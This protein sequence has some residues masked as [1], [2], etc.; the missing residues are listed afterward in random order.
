MTRARILSVNAS[1]YDQTGAELTAGVIPINSAYM[2]GDVRRYGAVG[3][4]TADD[5]VALQSAFNSVGNGDSV[6]IP[7]THK[8]TGAGCNLTNKNN[9]KIFGPGTIS[10]ASANVDAVAIL[11]VGTCDNV[12]IEGIT[13]KGAG[14]AGATYFQYG[15]YSVSGQTLSNITVNTCKFIDLN[16]GASFNA[17]SAGTYKKV[18]ISNCSFLRMTGSIGGQGYGTHVAGVF[19]ALIH[20][21]QYDDCGRHDIYIALGGSLTA[22][23]DSGIIISNNVSRNHRLTS[24]DATYRP[25]IYVARTWGV[26][27]IGNRV[28]DYWDGAVGVS[29]D[30]AYPASTG[31]VEIIGNTF[32]GRKNVLASVLLGEQ[33]NPTSYRIFRVDFKS[34]RFYVDEAVGAVQSEILINNGTNI[35]VTGNT[36]FLANTPDGVIRLI[37]LGAFAVSTTDF[38]NIFV[39]DNAVS[40]SASGTPA[41][42]LLRFTRIATAVCSLASK[43]WVKNNDIDTQFTVTNVEYSAARTGKKII[44]QLPNQ[45]V[46]GVYTAADT[47]PSVYGGVGFLEVTNAGATNINGLT[48]GVDGQIVQLVFT[49]ANTTLKHNV[50]GGGSAAI[51]LIGAADIVSVGRKTVGLIYDSVTYGQ[52]L[53]LAVAANT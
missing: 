49:D 44:D 14:N 43:I 3:D 9:V 46:K 10:I 23:V 27:I 40:G 21:N 16:A 39:R 37:E 19:D 38:D 18:K 48:D 7:F 8:V 47:T 2:P 28:I 42:I 20:G 50:G 22:G 13:F 4:G 1:G 30:T 52:W 24:H 15:I 32:S 17:A 25:A 12:T 45:P 29:Q 11:L 51:R 34:N 53:E 35:N 5:T 31:D 41:N 6:F 26:K 36:F 33:S